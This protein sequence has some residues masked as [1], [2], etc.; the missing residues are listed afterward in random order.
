M[1]KVKVAVFIS[2]ILHLSC[3]HRSI[4]LE[5]TANALADRNYKFTTLFPVSGKISFIAGSELVVT[6]NPNFPDVDSN[7]FAFATNDAVILRTEDGGKSWNRNQFGSGF[8]S[9]SVYFSGRIF[10][11]KK[12][13]DLVHSSWI[14]VDSTGRDFRHETTFPPFSYQLVVS[15]NLLFALFTDSLQIRHYYSRSADSGATWSTPQPLAY[16]VFQDAFLWNKELTYLSSD[17]DEQYYPSKIILSNIDSGKEYAKDLPM[18]FNAELLTMLGTNLLVIGNRQNEIQ[19]YSLDRNMKYENVGIYSASNR[20]SAEG[21][22]CYEGRVW[23]LVRTGE[24]S[25]FAYKVLRL[26]IVSKEWDSFDFEYD[27]YVEPYR[28]I[29]LD[30]QVIAWFYSGSGRIQKLIDD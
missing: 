13:E 25:N 6:S 3:Q 8:I 4:S 5:T 28:F 1:K 11:H 9:S 10:F 21:V 27:Q 24:G 26:N 29:V 18:D 16:R 20:I 12:E 19:L 14:S 30:E 15:G 23:L 7:Q 22:F 17:R 2:F